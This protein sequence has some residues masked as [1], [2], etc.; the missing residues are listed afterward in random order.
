MEKIMMEQA[1]LGSFLGLNTIIDIK[2][3]EVSMPLI[4]LYGIT[5][6]VLTV[7]GKTTVLSDFMGGMVIGGLILILHKL[8]R[9]GIGMG[10]GYLLMVT[11]MYLGFL[12]NLILIF[13]AMLL[14]AAVSVFLLICKRADRKKKMPFVPFLFIAYMGMVIL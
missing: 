2:K 6:V 12:K 8:T 9:G 7:L 4:I 5:G 14:T 10:D 13:Y 1:I 3:Q 11:G